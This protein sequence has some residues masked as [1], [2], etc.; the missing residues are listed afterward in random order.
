MSRLFRLTLALGGLLIVSPLLTAFGQTGTLPDFVLERTFIYDDAPFPS[1]HASTIEEMPDGDLLAAWFGGT[2][3]GEDDVEIW[4][5]RKTPGG[6]WSAPEAVTDFPEIPLW[7]PVLIQDAQKTWLFFKIGPSPREWVGGYRTSTDG[8]RTWGPITFLPAGQFGPIRAKPIVLSDGT[9][10]SGT[11]VEAGYRGDTPRDAPYRTWATWVERSRDGGTTWTKH[12]PIVVPGELYG[13]IQP[14]LWE[15][16]NGS[17]H[18]LMRSTQRV[19]AICESVSYDR[20]Q[21]WSPARPIE[22]PNPNAGIDVVKLED[23]RLVL[24]YNHTERGRTPIHVAVST[25]DG[26]TWHD[27][28]IVEDGPGEFSYPAIIQAS[29]GRIHLT[30]TWK[31]ERIRHVVIDPDQLPR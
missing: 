14:T 27:P 29:D 12:G 11:S 21:T 23:G 9:L 4:L 7:N 3:E 1:C 24:A 18:M 10:L 2:D 16:D 19:G 22:L 8:G 5:A 20:G 31:R 15:A 28:M 26:Q 13:V 30:Y 6:S 17:V 25:D